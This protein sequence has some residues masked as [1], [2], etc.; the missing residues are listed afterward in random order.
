MKRASR[1]ILILVVMLVVVGV[2]WWFWS[3]GNVKAADNIPT[4]H[5]TIVHPIVEWK[6]HGQTHWLTLTKDTEISAGD[7]IK[8]DSNG[9]AEIHW[10]ERGITRLDPN[11]DLVIDSAPDPDHYV[12]NVSINLHLTSGRVWSRMLKLLDLDSQ[13]S[14]RTDDVVAT[15]R[16]TAF[17]VR[18]GVDGLT[19]VLV[20]DSQVGVRPVNQPTEE[21]HVV[22][23]GEV[24]TFLKTAEA[25]KMQMRVMTKQD[26]W[27]TDNATKD[28]KFDEDLKAKMRKRLKEGRS[29]SGALALMSERMHAALAGGN[30]DALQAGYIRDHLGDAGTLAQTWNQDQ[31]VLNRLSGRNRERVLADIEARLFIDG[32]LKPDFKNKMQEMRKTGLHN[33]IRPNLEKP[34][35]L[36][37]SPPI[38]DQTPPTTDTPRPTEPTSLTPPVQEPIKLPLHTLT[39]SPTPSPTPALTTQ[40]TTI[41]PSAPEFVLVT[42][43]AVGLPDQPMILAVFMI[44]NGQRTNITDHVTFSTSADDGTVSGHTFTPAIS[45]TLSVTGTG[46]APDGHTITKTFPVKVGVSTE[47]APT[48]G[49]TINVQ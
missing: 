7:E 12:T 29:H 48:T 9:S 39:P 46:T 21:E 27:G 8:T 19:D 24:G 26:T 47:I 18:L 41:A 25:M 44:L 10:G 22:A 4:S 28:K 16:G 5:I 32:N 13:V 35:E 1:S 45:G 14:V 33:R 20:T 30:Q 11:T 36:P 2:G 6:Q 37:P 43:P 23:S 15:V 38:L 31:A 40:P 42:N 34:G 17:G 49:P 3:L